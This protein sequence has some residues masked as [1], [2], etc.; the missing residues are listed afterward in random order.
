M[1]ELGIPPQA[2]LNLQLCCPIYLGHPVGG[3]LVR[4]KLEMEVG[5][6]PLTFSPTCKSHHQFT[7]L[8]VQVFLNRA[9]EAHG[10]CSWRIYKLSFARDKQGVLGGGEE[11]QTNKL[12]ESF[13]KHLLKVC[14]AKV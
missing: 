14:L 3:N 12:L 1:A 6:H 7:F 10:L 8:S 4:N 2:S 11:E 9:D 13:A 5:L